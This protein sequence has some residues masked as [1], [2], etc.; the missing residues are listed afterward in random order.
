MR[1]IAFAITV[2]LLALLGKAMKVAVDA[3]HYWVLI[4]VPVLAVWAGYY[5]GDDDDRAEYRAVGRRITGW[6]GFR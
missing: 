4:A 6:F 3:G 2:A 1:W 5:V